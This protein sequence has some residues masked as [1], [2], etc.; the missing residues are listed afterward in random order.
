MKY[1]GREEIITS[2]TDWVVPKAKD[3]RFQ[4]AVYGGGGSGSIDGNFFN[5]VGG[6]G[7]GS[8]EYAFGEFTLEEGDRIQ[9]TIG[10]GGEGIQGSNDVSEFIGH[11]VGR[12]GGTTSF[13]TYLAASGGLGG[14]INQGGDGGNDGGD[15]GKTADGHYFG[16]GSTGEVDGITY[17]SGGGGA[18]VNARGVGGSADTCQ[19]NGGTSAGG[20]GC[21]VEKNGGKIIRRIGA[22]GNGVCVIRWYA[23]IG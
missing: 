13:G 2:T 10:K 20:A 4:V 3:Q 1:M 16:N 5:S 18:A 22:G 8:G 12:T 14:N 11:I 17:S 19:G 23:P 7:G 21:F 9:V 6:A 15:T